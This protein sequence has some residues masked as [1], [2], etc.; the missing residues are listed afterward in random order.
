[1]T[2]FPVP[3]RGVPHPCPA[4]QGVAMAAVALKKG[5]ELWKKVKPLL[6]T[7]TGVSEKLRTITSYPGL[8]TCKPSDAAEWVRKL[9]DVDTHVDAKTRDTKVQ[10]HAKAHARAEA[11]KQKKKT[12][13][14]YY[15]GVR[16]NLVQLK[17][18]EEGVGQAVGRFAAAPGRRR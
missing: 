15:D 6:L 18:D 3:K 17:V 14:E 2:P 13:T 8:A 7:K 16:R 5:V 4:H 9:Q 10:K 12:W 11:L 1:M